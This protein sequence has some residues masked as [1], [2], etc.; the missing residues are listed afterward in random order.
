MRSFSGQLLDEARELFIEG[1]YAEAE[2]LL[3]QPTLQNS[4]NPEVFQMLATIYYNRGEFNKAI[5]T[6][7]T[8]LQIDPSYTDAA[9]GV[10]IILNDLGRYEEAKK[11]FEDAQKVIDQRR[12]QNQNQQ[13]SQLSEKI[14]QKHAELGDLYLQAKKYSTALEQYQLAY[15]MTARKEN[16]VLQIT[17]CCIQ[18]GNHQE[19]SRHLKNYLQMN[20][21]SVPARLKLGLVMYNTHLIAE[22]VEQWENVIRLDPKNESAIKYLNMAQ[23]AGITNLTI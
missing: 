12:Q 19:A 20:P 1:K 16:V 11:I 15:N 4:N 17:E 6:F 8:A 10:S 7:K 22:A 13:N 3:N 9:V 5:K 21:K 18:S 14:A 2:P 23:A